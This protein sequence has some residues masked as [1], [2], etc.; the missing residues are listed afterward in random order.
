M[1]SVNSARLLAWLAFLVGFGLPISTAFDNIAAGL[2]LLAW[3]LT[4]DWQQRWQRLSSNPASYAVGGLLLLAAVGMAWS[5]GSTRET[6]RYFE[7]YAALLLALCLFSVSFERSH[8]QLALRGFASAAL[9]TAIVSFAFKFGIVPASWFP[10]RLPSNPA[11]FKLHITHGFFV[12][13]GAYFL[14]I[15]AM[16]ATDRRWRIGFAL[17]ALITAA[18][19]LAIEGRTGYLVLATLFAY[20]FIQRFRWRGAAVSAILLAA[21]IMVAQQFPESAAMRRM[22]TGIEE[23]KAWQSGEKIEASSSMGVRM[24]FATTSLGLIAARP[25]LGVGTGGFEVAYRAAT[26]EGNVISNN[27]H[28][29]YLLT[30]VQFG[31]VGLAVLLSLFVVLWGGSDRFAFTDRLLAHGVLLAYL[32]GNLFNSFLYDHSEARFFAWAIGLIFSGAV[33]R[34]K[35][36]KPF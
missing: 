27:P 12:A 28:N 31:L 2:L 36:A 33:F 5:L 34:E 17:A 10:E 32:V 22:S 21:G 26:P 16:Q 1:P 29:Q 3:A 20:L 9:L 23:M 8:R 18:N 4:G 15:E 35:T 14:M 30:T 13:I 19:T 6:L 24:Q 25:F 7:K 11:I